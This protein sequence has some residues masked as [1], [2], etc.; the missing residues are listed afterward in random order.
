[1]GPAPPAISGLSFLP[2]APGIS[3]G[4][5]HPF[6]HSLTNN[7]PPPQD[8]RLQRLCSISSD[9]TSSPT[10]ILTRD[11]MTLFFLPQN[12]TKFT[13]VCLWIHLII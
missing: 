3:H 13:I 11:S 8:L 4:S 10:V 9:L 6:I 5:G 12:L 1:M 7:S 2:R